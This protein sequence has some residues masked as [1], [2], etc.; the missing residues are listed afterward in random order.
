VTH[1]ADHRTYCRICGAICGLVATVERSSAGERVVRVRGD[2]DDPISHGYA[3]PKGRALGV[4]HHHPDRLDR[5][6]LRGAAVAWDACLDDLATALT[7]IQAD[8]GRDAV[9]IYLATASSFDALGGRTAARFAGALGTRNRYSAITIDAACKPLVAELMAGRSDLLPAID[10]E[11]A[12][13]TIFLGCNPVVSHGHYNAFPDPVT[14]LR[15]L[16]RDGREL[17]VIDPRRTETAA[18]A[19][20]HLAPRPGTDWAVLAYLVRELLAPDGGADADY[21]AEHAAGVAE[22]AAAVAPWGVEAA[23]SITGLPATDLAALLASI[24]R[25]GRVAAQTGTGTTMSR[26]A[27]VTE[28]LTWAL[29]VITGSYDRPGGMWFNPGFLSGHDRRAI[30]AS[31]AADGPPSRPDLPSRMGEYPVAALVDEIE[32]GNVRAL[33]VFGGNPATAFPEAGRVRAALE[34]LDVLAVADVLR[35]ETVQLATHVLPCTAQLERADVP[36]FVDQFAPEVSSRYTP[37]VVAPVAER[38]PAWRVFG[39]LGRRMGTEVVGDG[40]DLSE[41]TEDDLLAPIAGRGRAPFDVLRDERVV[42]DEPS[43]FGWVERTLPEGRWQLAPHVLV[44]QLA[45]LGGEAA[46]VGELVMIPRRQLRHMNS[47]L[48]D[49]APRGG[50]VDEPDVLVHPDDAARAGVAD[51]DDV[52]LVSP[53]G[54][55]TYRVRT[56]LGMRPGVV[57]VPHGWGGD[58][59]V[60]ALTSAGDCDPLT[61]MVEL[62]GLRVTMRAVSL[63]PAR[64]SRPS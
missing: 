52:E 54:V 5:P 34:S 38:W 48:R 60:G 10:Q 45:A 30:G 35:T 63:R 50:R 26:T 16:A 41:V 39:E 6:E 9:A 3:C 43:A 29:H 23:A 58:A 17:W 15:A 2:A 28:W 19:T 33:V 51:G 11:R 13:L 21:L 62:S 14:R 57:G 18:L 53:N 24:R 44:A 46:R 7:A 61:G 27:N 42:V 56:D 31:P 47:L 1:T 12:T 36:Y 37:A 55:A 59:G 4:L 8:H 22:L 49:A 64:A 40:I 32:A 25:H 20:R